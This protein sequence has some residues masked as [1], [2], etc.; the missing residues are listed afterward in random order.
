MGE[1]NDGR[2]RTGK[3]APGNSGGPGRPR[4]V[5][6]QTYLKA[7]RDN[8][9]VEAWGQIVAKAVALALEGDAAARQWLGRHAMGTAPPTLRELAG[10]EHAAGSVDEA[11]ERSIQ[12]ARL[13]TEL[14]IDGGTL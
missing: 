14:Q 5:V 7:L 13:M 9:P 10:L 4:R 6:E 3:F 1:T 8:L 11:V 12:G 2:D